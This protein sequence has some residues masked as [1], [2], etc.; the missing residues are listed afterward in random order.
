MSASFGGFNSI[1]YMLT[2]ICE[3]TSI[4]GFKCGMY[5]TNVYLIIRSIFQFGC[6]FMI[7]CALYIY[8]TG[9]KQKSE[10]VTHLELE[11]E[12]THARQ[13]E[14]VNEEENVAQ[15]EEVDENTRDLNNNN[16]NEVF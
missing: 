4:I 9:L 14:Q 3:V 7:L 6:Y 13:E 8:Y 12:T 5:T 16:K 15:E 2:M 10:S 1:F 11:L